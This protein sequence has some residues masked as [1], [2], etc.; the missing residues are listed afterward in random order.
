MKQAVVTGG[1]SPEGI[2]WATAVALAEDGHEVIV[3][4]VS[5]SELERTPRHPDIR[6]VVLDV[7]DTDAVDGLFA[8]LNRLDVLVNC[9]GMADPSREFTPD[10]FARTVDVN[11]TG[12]LRCCAAAR[13]LLQAAKGSIVN[14]AS[15]YAIF[16]SPAAPGYAASKAGVVQLTK[17]LAVA[18]A[19]EI[20]VNAVA[21][22]WVVTGM[23]QA[24]FDDPV[25]S[26][27]IKART[28]IGR[29]GRPGDLADVILF[30]ASPA[31][32][33]VTGVLLPVDGGYSCVG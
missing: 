1:A 33:F 31:A 17:S 20:R 29:F 23:A 8:G 19:P 3:T 10:G 21:P 32:R 27:A 5:S 25:W 2:G 7:T 11:L 22:G 12:S 6:G 13:P 14:V 26:G 18:W 4:G 24:V 9:A 16:G 30:L 28:P 15:M